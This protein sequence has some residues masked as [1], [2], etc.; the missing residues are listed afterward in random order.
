VWF[1]FSFYTVG[2]LLIADKLTSTSSNNIWFISFLASP[3][4]VLDNKIKPSLFYS[5]IFQAMPI[6]YLHI[7][8]EF[9]LCCEVY[10]SSFPW[11]NF[12]STEFILEFANLY[13]Q[14]LHHSCTEVQKRQILESK[15]WVPT[16]TWRGRS[17]AVGWGTTLQTGK[18]RVRFPMVLLEFF[19][20]I[21]LSVALWPW[22]RLS[23]Y[24]ED[25]LGGKCGRCLGLTT[26]PS[27]S[28]D[29]LDIWQPQPPGT[30]RVC[31]GL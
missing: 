23:L 8:A 4:D 24:Q 14:I 28:A 12:Y 6:L 30:L 21:I 11:G 5:Q 19:I 16:Q 10:V 22:G 18:S 3:E 27:S 9:Q 17:G 25:F 26:L 7:T 31:S 13:L 29:C 2:T 20:G 15:F 1:L